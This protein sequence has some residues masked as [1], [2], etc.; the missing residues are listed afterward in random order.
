PAG[1]EGMEDG[2]QPACGDR[3]NDLTRRASAGLAALSLCGAGQGASSARDYRCGDE[4]DPPG[5]LAVGGA[6]GKDARVAVWPARPGGIGSPE[7]ANRI[8]NGTENWNKGF[9]AVCLI[10]GRPV[11]I[12]GSARFNDSPDHD[13]GSVARYRI[14]VRR[15]MPKAVAI[16]CNERPRPRSSTARCDGALVVP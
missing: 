14:T 11:G 5:V 15:L 8:S 4:F 1:D 10:G 7:F 16:S 13:A 3:G 12:G 9:L 6:A 2:V